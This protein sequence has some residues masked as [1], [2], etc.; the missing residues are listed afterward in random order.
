MKCTVWKRKN[1]SLCIYKGIVLKKYSDGVTTTAS[2]VEFDM[3]L[4]EGDFTL[5][6]F[7]MYD[8]RGKKIP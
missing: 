3:T 8:K 7:P 1:E 5:P 4:G 2:K 6:D